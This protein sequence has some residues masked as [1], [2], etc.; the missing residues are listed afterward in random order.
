MLSVMIKVRCR[1]SLVQS[2][3]DLRL[4]H[5][6]PALV[7]VVCPSKTG[8]G[9]IVTIMCSGLT[10]LKGASYELGR[11]MQRQVEW[12]CIDSRRKYK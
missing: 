9:G 5:P 11:T 10:H 2:V 8:S 12:P 1:A 4:R 7:A 6:R 3:V